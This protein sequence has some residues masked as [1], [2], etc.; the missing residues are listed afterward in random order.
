[1]LLLAMAVKLMAALAGSAVRRKR[2]TRAPRAVARDAT[3]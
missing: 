3:S 1:V 2:K